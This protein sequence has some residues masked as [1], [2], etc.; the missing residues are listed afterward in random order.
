MQLGNVDMCKHNTQY[1][2][3]ACMCY[4]YVHTLSRLDVCK[5][6]LKGYTSQPGGQSQW[7][8][9]G[10]GRLAPVFF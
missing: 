1:T 9:L 7:L 10:S 8:L 5:P 6:A 3:Y 2:F 4:M